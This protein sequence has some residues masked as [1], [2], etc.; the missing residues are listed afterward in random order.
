MGVIAPLALLAGG[1]LFQAVGAIAGGAAAN[2][3]AKYNAQVAS[4]NA[5]M[6]QRQAEDAKERGRIEEQRFRLQ[7]AQLRGQQAASLAANGVDISSGSPLQVLADSAGM[8]ELDAASVR[9]QAAREAYGYQVES[10]NYLNESTLER[11]RGKSA[12][13]ASYFEAGSSLLTGAGRVA[14]NWPQA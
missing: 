13:R 7:A 4:N 2:N 10:A 6:A 3:A 9:D 1:A 8:A 12:K 5:A 14:A 11:A